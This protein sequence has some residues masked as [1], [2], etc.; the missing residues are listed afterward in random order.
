MEGASL[1]STGPS[2][3]GP[4]SAEFYSAFPA[5][6]QQGASL[7][8]FKS[9]HRTHFFWWPSFPGTDDAYTRPG[10]FAWR[11]TR[12]YA[13][14]TCDITVTPAEPQAKRRWECEGR[15]HSQ[16][17]AGCSSPFSPLHPLVPPTGPSTFPDLSF[18]GRKAQT[19]QP[20]SLEER[21]KI[22]CLEA[23]GWPR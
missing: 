3:S 18:P 5:P 4:G 10:C 2:L 11:P 20:V 9:F 15:S 13:L 8:S 21:E 22:A 12:G 14:H 19:I 17:S 6:S 7:P 23:G 16:D 1:P